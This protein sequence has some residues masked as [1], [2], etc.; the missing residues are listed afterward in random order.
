VT[1]VAAVDLGTNSTR[2]L[3][4]DVAGSRLDDV[5]RRTEITRLGEGVDAHRRLQPAAIARVRT[6]LAGYRR[7]IEAL[8]AER[9]LAVGTSALRDAEDGRAF[10]AE[11]ERR[12]R[13]TTR[14]LSGDE[15]AALTLRGVGALDAD[16]LL[17]DV[18]GGS[19][20]LTAS[21]SRTSLD[22]GS[23]RLTERFL[24]SDPPTD[25]EL[26][27]AAAFVRGLLPPLAPSRAV[28]VAGTVEQLHVL[29]GELTA[30]A[31]ERQLER[32]GGLALAERLAV[33][34]LVPGRAPVIV[35]GALIVREVLARYR[36][37][38]LDFSR[39]DLL[40]GVALAA[41]DAAA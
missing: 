39:R 2:L 23:V 8:G 11:V 41:A 22:V 30:A 25:A 28:G 35:A 20:E 12:Y 13:F 31:V 27:R 33:P 19:T 14:L 36:L 4:A 18:G 24:H 9:T 32:L 3:V 40:D 29:A 26:E 17:V 38:R 5:L 37:P 34:G 10:L 15:E 1:R 21:G 16:T 7:Q 6:V